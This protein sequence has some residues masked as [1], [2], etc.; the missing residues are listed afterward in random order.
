MPADPVDN[1]LVEDIARRR[2][3]LL[4]LEQAVRSVAVQRRVHLRGQAAAEI[5]GSER[6]MEGARERGS[7]R[8]RERVFTRAFSIFISC[9]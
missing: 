8:A 2:R 3:E 5:R 4:E 9:D 6:P 1:P 7:E